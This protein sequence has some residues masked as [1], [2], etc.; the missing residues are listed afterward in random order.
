MFNY[1][2][3]IVITRATY[4]WYYIDLVSLRQFN[5]LFA[6]IKELVVMLKSD[7]DPKKEK[8]D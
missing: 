2:K 5:L 8:N 4:H 1:L 6:H 3:R 7:T